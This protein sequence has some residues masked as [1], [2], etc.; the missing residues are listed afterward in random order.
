MSE[1]EQGCVGWS[2]V[3]EIIY[4]L[5]LREFQTE[6]RIAVIKAFFEKSVP[7]K[8]IHDMASYIH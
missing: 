8:I 3:T 1:M 4:L 2:P 7:S 5:S 6:L